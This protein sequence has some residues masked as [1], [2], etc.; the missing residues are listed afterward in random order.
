MKDLSNSEP[1]YFSD[2]ISQAR[3]FYLDLNPRPSDPLAV[4]SGG[5]DAAGE[6]SQSA[7]IRLAVQRL[8]GRPAHD[9]EVALGLEFLNAPEDRTAGAK[10]DLA[11]WEQYAQVLL[12]ANEFTFVD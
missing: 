10:V 6:A 4:V 5:V 9:W 2:Q 3:R 12:G 7:R 1:T 11:R 8:Y